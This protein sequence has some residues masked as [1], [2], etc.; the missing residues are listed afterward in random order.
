MDLIKELSNKFKIK[1]EIN[2]NNIIFKSEKSN[3]DEVVEEVKI[4]KEC[5][6]NIITTALDKLKEY[7]KIFSKE[8]IEIQN[9]INIYNLQF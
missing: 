9:N 2:E 3:L 5:I 4:K 7:D 6:Q 8:L 1:N